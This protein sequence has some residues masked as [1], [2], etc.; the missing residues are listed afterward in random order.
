MDLR[1][2]QASLAAERPPHGL[3]A[4]LRALWHAARGNWNRAHTIVAVDDG[5]SA[6]RVHAY[7][8]RKQG[9]TTNAD[10]WYSRAG[11]KRP[12]RTL[13][14]EWRALVRQFLQEQ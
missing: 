11:A 6:A 10:Y 14:G 7:L 12:R 13:D 5:R 1:E 2:F 9:D 4:P 3:S 8:H